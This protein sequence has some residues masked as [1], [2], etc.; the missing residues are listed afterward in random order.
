MTANPDRQS[1]KA[2]ESAASLAVKGNLQCHICAWARI[3]S[4]INE[5]NHSH[6]IHVLLDKQSM[7]WFEV[8]PLGCITASLQLLRT[9][10]HTCVNYNWVMALSS[11]K[12][13]RPA[14]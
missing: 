3:P 9:C 11:V 1:I 4:A 6:S 12:P 5:C 10:R 8:R 14:R 2:M 13:S 7:I